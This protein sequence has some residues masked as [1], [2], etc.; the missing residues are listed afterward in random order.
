MPETNRLAKRILLLTAL[1]VALAGCGG[2]GGNRSANPASEVQ[3]QI[4]SMV[5][6][7]EAE[8][9]DHILS[10]YSAD[11]Q[12]PDGETRTTLATDIPTILS[13][14]D[15]LAAA[16][17][18]GDYVVTNNG[19]TVTVVGGYS[20]V[21]ADEGTGETQTFSTATTDT[22]KKEPQGWRLLTSADLP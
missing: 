21:L 10:F 3:A 9:A 15:V 19:S 13:A 8:D 11:Y 18:T 1:V 20:I 5:E 14:F 16:T 7:W 17:E 2:G 6:A 4:A 22:W 12:G